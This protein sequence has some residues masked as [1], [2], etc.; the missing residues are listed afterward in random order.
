[1]QR[2][3]TARGCGGLELMT[4]QSVTSL[5]GAGEELQLAVDQDMR[6]SP[7]SAEELR[8]IASYFEDFPAI[9]LDCLW[10]AFPAQAT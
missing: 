8:K 3:G 10:Q 7:W 5:V 1:M 4:N 6:L 9:P 2:P